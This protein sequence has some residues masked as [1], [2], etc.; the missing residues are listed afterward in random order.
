MLDNI[1]AGPGLNRKQCDP[2]Q[3]VEGVPNR[4]IKNHAAL[5]SSFAGEHIL[6]VGGSD[7][8]RDPVVGPR[9]LLNVVFGRAFSSQYFGQEEHRDSDYGETPQWTTQFT[10]VGQHSHAGGLAELLNA[11]R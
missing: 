7:P 6:S 8:D 10:K 2:S 9:C 3:G 4:V 5:G 1:Q 11:S